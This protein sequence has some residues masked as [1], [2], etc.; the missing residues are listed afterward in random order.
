MCFSVLVRVLFAAATSFS[1]FAKKKF[2]FCLHSHSVLVFPAG[3][4]PSSWWFRDWSCFHYVAQPPL[5]VAQSSVP[6]GK[7]IMRGWSGHICFS[8]SVAGSDTR[9]SAWYEPFTWY[10]FEAR[11]LRNVIF[12]WASVSWQQLYTLNGWT[13]VFGEQSAIL[14]MFDNM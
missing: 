1:G 8:S 13:R 11:G 6:S 4:L 2:I 14:A 5:R 10:H 9:Q 7:W 3:G 12:G